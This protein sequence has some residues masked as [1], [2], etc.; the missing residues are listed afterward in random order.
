MIIQKDKVVALHYELRLDNAEGE[1]VEQT[2][3][4]EPLVFIYGHGSMLEVFEANLSGLKTGDTFAFGINAGDAYGEYD[5]E[6]IV[7]IDKNVFEGH[8]DLIQIGS[9]I[10]MQGP[11][12][13]M[14]R[15]TVVHFDDEVVV[16]DFNH[17]MAGKNLYFTGSIASLR[18]AEAEELAHGHVHGEGG[19][20]HDHD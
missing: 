18:D 1:F 15:G 4:Q 6:N 13:Q 10:P 12:G 16:M 2:D 11:E 17:P 5:E 8:F 20:H 9:V 7:P 19:V 3:P 14:V